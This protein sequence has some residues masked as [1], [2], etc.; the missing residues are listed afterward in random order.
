MIEAISTVSVQSQALRSSPQAVSS[1][2]AKAEPVRAAGGMGLLRVR[3]D[4]H[5]DMAIL[6]QRSAETGEVVRQYP[7]EAQIRAF[8]RA[9]ELEARSQKEIQQSAPAPVREV[10][11][12]VVESAPSAPAPAPAREAPA[13]SADAAASQSIIV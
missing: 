11:A 1:Y 10:Q 7:S 4:N 2:V 12:P 13:P 8:Q 9:A 6:E 3:M 5:L